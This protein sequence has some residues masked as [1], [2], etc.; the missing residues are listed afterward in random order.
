MDIP[1]V[2]FT[3]I[4][5]VLL[6]GLKAA[7]DLHIAPWLVRGL[8]W[9]PTR[10]LFRH[11]WTDLS[12]DWSATWGAGGSSDFQDVTRRIITLKMWQF[13]PYCYGKFTTGGASYSLFA[14]IKES[15][16]VGDW[17][18]TNDKH[19]YFGALQLLLISE[20]RL[21]GK[22][23][24]HSKTVVAVRADTFEATRRDR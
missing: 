3:A 15:Y 18:A 8:G 1:S 7:L 2:V 10:S 19:G 17:Y 23:I 5:F 12:G 21:E 9:V 16:L 6:I 22:W 14:R 20:R 24:G 11:K 4:G 13:G